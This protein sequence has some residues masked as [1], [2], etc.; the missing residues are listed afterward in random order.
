ME[1]KGLFYS[2]KWAR[3]LNFKVDMVETDSLILA[4]AL[5][6]STSNRS[7]FQDLI[8]DVQ[9]ELSYLPTVC[10]NHVYRDG[11]QAAHGLAKQALVLDN[12]CTWLEDFP[13]AILSIVVKDSLIL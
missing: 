13:S 3:Q 7:S 2:L 8:F 9:T 1:A 4:N 5:R 10:V 11:N 12:V 6:K